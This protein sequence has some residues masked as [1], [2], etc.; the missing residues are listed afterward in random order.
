MPVPLRNC[1]EIMGCGREPGGHGVDALGICPSTTNEHTDGLNR[2]RKGGRICWAVA[3]TFCDGQVHG[4]F[5]NK[6]ATCM[7]CRF[8]L[9]VQAEEGADFRHVPDGQP[10]VSD[11][12]Q[13]TRAY[14][15]LHQ[16]Y[17]ELR[18]ARA[19]LEHT[20]RLREVGQL[21][22][23]VAHEINNPLTFVLHSLREVDDG[24]GAYL[25][26][27][28]STP[29][30]PEE[31]G[32]LK[33]RTT[34]A[35]VGAN[36]VRDIV[37]RLLSLA[38]GGEGAPRTVVPVDLPMD[39][40]VTMAGHEIR[41]RAKLTVDVPADLKVLGNESQLGQVFLNLL[42]NAARAIDDGDAQRNEVRVRARAV[43]P[44][45]HIEI[46]DTGR[47][48][49]AQ[50]LDRL[51]EPFFTTRAAAEGIGLGLPVSR[52]IIESHGGT[53]T[54][55]SRAGRGTT[56]TVVLPRVEPE[57]ARTVAEPTP[58]Q[59]PLLPRRGRRVLA[60]DD[61]RAIGEMIGDLLGQ[62]QDVTAVTSATEAL[63]YLRD[64][65]FDLILLDLM[66]PGVSGQELFEW[67][68]SERPDLAGRVVFMT[69][70]AFT[71]QASSF[72]P[73][74]DN[75]VLHK[76][77]GLGELREVLVDRFGPASAPAPPEPPAPR[78]GR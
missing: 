72:L 52:R 42:L 70:G 2:G 75:R 62:R 67:L 43:D 58:E 77:F 3:G 63:S 40:A 19:Q 26:P 69:G 68:E 73:T 22:A 47:G 21:A 61:E 24:L 33:R 17:D 31:L 48:I 14:S 4:T 30:T 5:A 8:Y 20:E 7:S 71:P 59:A 41:H 11:Y 54:V 65:D 78:V 55:K 34:Q 57:Q 49:P 13:I 39:A 37:T 10:S 56:F 6:L 27:D 9:Q 44:S 15:Q 51:F 64:G 12:E 53:M 76:P 29:A 23:G 36:R 35:L 60:V 32:D 1:W 38:R 18:Q 74:I 28:G 45:I 50:L 16:L 25:D 46:I 66:M